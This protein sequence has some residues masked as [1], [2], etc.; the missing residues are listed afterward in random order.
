MNKNPES[1][2]KL[3]GIEGNYQ[4][5]DRKNV[6]FPIVRDCDNCVA[7]ILN[8]AP[9]CILNKKDDILSLDSNMLRLDFTTEN[10]KTVKNVI[11]EHMNVLQKATKCQQSLEKYMKSEKATGGHF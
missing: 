4:L 9:I 11:Q 10:A 2:C 1:Y 7:F 8:S 3:K 6:K 5:K